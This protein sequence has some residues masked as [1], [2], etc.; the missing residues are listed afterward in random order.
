MKVVLVGR[1]SDL[2]G[3]KCRRCQAKLRFGQ[4]VLLVTLPTSNF[5]DPSWVAH[6]ECVRAVID[7]GPKGDIE[8]LDPRAALAARI[9]EAQAA[10]A[11]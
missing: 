2:T 10:G 9:A 6:A 8:D 11:S 3:R 4:S 1:G 7:A 5:A